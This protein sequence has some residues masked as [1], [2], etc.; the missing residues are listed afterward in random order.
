[1]AASAAVQVVLLDIGKVTRD[2]RACSPCYLPPYPSSA[3]PTPATHPTIRISCPV[4]NCI[5]PFI[6]GLA[7]PFFLVGL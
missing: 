2:G 7:N 3:Q 4:Q 1:M 5:S 6:K